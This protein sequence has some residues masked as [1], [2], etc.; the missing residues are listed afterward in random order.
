MDRD[1]Y[2]VYWYE[3]LTPLEWDYP[4]LDG[5]RRRLT[6]SQAGQPGRRKSCGRPERDY[7]LLNHNA[8]SSTPG[9][10][11]D[12]FPIE[13]LVRFFA[14]TSEELQ[15]SREGPTRLP[16][17]GFTGRRPTKRQPMPTH[18]DPEDT[19]AQMATHQRWSSRVAE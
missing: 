12:R 14:A 13:D 4:P 1:D 5:P 2:F 11:A 8:D 7:S 6:H 9:L 19:F 17:S 10:K 16:I 3:Q 18:Q 15:H